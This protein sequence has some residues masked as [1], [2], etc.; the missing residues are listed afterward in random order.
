MCKETVEESGMYN[1]CD[2]CAN[3]TVFSL[4]DMA[5]KMALSIVGGS[6]TG[7]RDEVLSCGAIQ[8]N[9]YAGVNIIQTRRGKGDC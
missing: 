3:P 5:R 4:F 8:L 2:G 9:P 1:K 7:P 6:V